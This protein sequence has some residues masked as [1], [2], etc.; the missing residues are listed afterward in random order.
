[1]EP[2]LIISFLISFLVTFL[3]LPFWIKRA[4][5]FGLVGKDMNK[6]DK[7]KVA[8]MG[9]VIALLGFLLGVLFFISV[10]TFYFSSN[11][12]IIEIFSIL[13]SVLIVAFVGMIDGLLGW[14]IG[15]RRRYRIFLCLF[16]AIPLMVINTGSNIINIPL[17]GTVNFG[18]SIFAMAT[19]NT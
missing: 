2:L 6:Y 4:G 19:W 14:R 12:N 7:P 9:G 16:A 11:D 3:V 13:S 5:K 8:E 1:M 18:P 17:I 15:L 10:R